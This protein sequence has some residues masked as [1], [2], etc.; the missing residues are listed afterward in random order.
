MSKASELA[1]HLAS[2]AANVLAA[3]GYATDIGLRVFRGRMS[4]NR[5]DLPCVVLVEGDET[6]IDQKNAKVNVD[7]TFVLEGHDVCDP[8]QPNDKGH[9]IVADLKKAVFGADL[10]LGGRLRSKDEIKYLGK[11]IGQRPEGGDVIAAS[12]SFSIAQVED[13]SSP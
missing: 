8:E 13:L 10:T 11:A 12:I 9:L 7:T 3:N 4:L 2:L 1:A 5:E 6:V